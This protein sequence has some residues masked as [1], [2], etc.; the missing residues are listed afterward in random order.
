M[1][2]LILT[3][4]L[5]SSCFGAE[6]QG[7]PAEHLVAQLTVELAKRFAFGDETIDAKPEITRNEGKIEVRFNGFYVTVAAG[8]TLITDAEIQK[9]KDEN[10]KLRKALDGDKQ[11]DPTA[12]ALFAALLASDDQDCPKIGK[13]ARATDFMGQ[14]LTFSTSD[15]KVDVHIEDAEPYSLKI[16]EFAAELSNL[17]DK[18]KAEQGGTGQP[19]TRS[20]SKSE[21]SDKPQPEAEG[22]S[23]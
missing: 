12:K 9:T 14:T 19:A 22:R 18:P 20:Q 1:K 7:K 10:Q 6:A 15:G 4:A 8:G 2:S 13:R 11:M 3:F 23:R 17:Y 5:T 16:R 21:G